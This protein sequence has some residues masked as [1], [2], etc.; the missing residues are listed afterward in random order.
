MSSRALDGVRV[1]DLSRLLPGPYA[2]QILA[3]RGADVIKV[4]EP[5]LGDYARYSEPRVDGTGLVFSMVNRGKR[6]VTLNLAEDQGREVFLDLAGEADV[7]FEGFSPGTMDKLDI[8]YETLSSVNPELIYC[9][10]SGYG[11]SGP[12]RDRPG[13]DLNYAGYTGLLDM[14]RSDPDD[15]PAVPGFPMGDMVS[16]LTAAQE[17][18][19]ALLS[20]E[21]GNGGGEYLDLSI[22][23]SLLDLSQV[24]SGEAMAGESPPRPAGTVLTGKYPCY[25]IY[26]AAD[27]KYVTLAALEPKFW[28]TFCQA[29][30]R[31]DLEPLHMSDDPDERSKLRTELES[32]FRDKT[33]DQWESDLGEQATMVGAVL[34]PRE[35][36]NN[37]HFVERGDFRTGECRVSIRADYEDPRDLP[38]KGEHNEEV[39]TSL[40]YDRSTLDDWE[41][42]GII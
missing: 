18:T 17:I 22:A 14:T 26:E 32:I 27:G 41:E 9:S 13:H 36:I 11:Q 31:E 10:L 24:I 3:D 38:E 40:G 30:G 28:K 35:V 1:V 25:S 20:R 15:T 7:V 12:Y 16:G 39:F 4:E 6:A 33:R 2:T 21:L 5:E 23:E 19:T 8:G 34:E 37:E 42:E 29:I